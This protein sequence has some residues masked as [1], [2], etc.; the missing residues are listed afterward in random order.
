M[1]IYNSRTFPRLEGKD[2][3]F[4]T[5]ASG[6]YSV[7]SFAE[8]PV[9][10]EKIEKILC[11]A[12]YAP[13]AVNFQP[14]RIVKVVGEEALK[15]L[16]GCVKKY[17]PSPLAFIV[18]YDRNESWKRKGDGHDSGEVDASIVATHM[19]FEAWELGIGSVWIGM[20]YTDKIREE[21]KLPESVVPVAILQCGYPSEDSVPGPYHAQ[22]KQIEDFCVTDSF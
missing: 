21:F 14:Q 6:R 10:N 16:E 1:L 9:E 17:F 2:M 22:S 12:R 15:K 8:K 20:F 5:L 7:R 3:D 13:T 11:A 19:M 4:L 18:C